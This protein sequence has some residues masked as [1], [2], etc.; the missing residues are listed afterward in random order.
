M[1]VTNLVRNHAKM[2]L[3]TLNSTQHTANLEIYSTH[4]CSVNCRFTKSSALI[5]SLF[6]STSSTSDCNLY[7]EKRL[8]N[9]IT[10]ITTGSRKHSPLK[11]VR[12][13]VQENNC[14]RE[15][16]AGCVLACKHKELE[17]IHGIPIP[18]ASSCVVRSI[19]PVFSRMG[20]RVALL[21]VSIK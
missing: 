10:I 19:P 7:T 8:L 15:Q 2:F 1:Q 12:I 5:L 11:D 9:T 14:K 17:C 20:V 4:T 16:V 13:K 3:A 6:P 18:R 21:T